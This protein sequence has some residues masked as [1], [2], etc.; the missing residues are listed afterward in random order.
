MFATAAT[1][2][3]SAGDPPTTIDVI[4]AL[5]PLEPTSVS[6]PTSPAGVS[7]S[8]RVPPAPGDL[9]SSV[10]AMPPDG[11]EDPVNQPAPKA[12]E[13]QSIEPI[14]PALP[15]DSTLP[16]TLTSVA[17]RRLLAIDPQV[18]PYK[19]NVPREYVACGDEF[20]SQVRICVT[21]AGTVSSVQVLR[22]SIPVID[23]QLPV[24]LARWRY[25]PYVVDGRAT[26]FCYALNYAVR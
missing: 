26:A 17:G 4:P 23:L 19:V 1:P 3:P 10:A 9:V 25:F 14:I 22:L 11:Y 7:V 8:A 15:P 6:A 16:P 5:Q 24:V 18:N 2:A 12:H 21:E 20:V 13:A